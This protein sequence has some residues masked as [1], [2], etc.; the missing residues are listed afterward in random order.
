MIKLCFEGSFFSCCKMKGKESWQAVAVRGGG[1][2]QDSSLTWREWV[3]FQ[4]FLK[5]AY[6]I[7]LWI[8]NRWGVRKSFFLSNLKDGVTHS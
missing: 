8:I 2:G 4:R 7:S 6:R 1:L 3:R 5:I